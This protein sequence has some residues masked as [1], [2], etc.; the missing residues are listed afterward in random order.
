[1]YEDNAQQIC[2]YYKMYVLNVYSS[3][4]VHDLLC[5]YQNPTHVENVKIKLDQKSRQ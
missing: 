5:R 3:L 4:Y 2:I 1:M